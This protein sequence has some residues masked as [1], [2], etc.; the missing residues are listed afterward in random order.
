MIKQIKSAL[1]AASSDEDGVSLTVQIVSVII[2][3]IDGI[4]PQSLVYEQDKQW[5]DHTVEMSASYLN[6][7]VDAYR[8]KMINLIRLN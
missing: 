1:Q 6:V 4:V 3:T 7:C 5:P 2:A 8:K